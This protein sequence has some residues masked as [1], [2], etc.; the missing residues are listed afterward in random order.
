LARREHV[1][2]VS[3]PRVARAAL[4]RYDVRIMTLAQILRRVQHLPTQQRRRLARQIL[5]MNGKLHRSSSRRS[6]R[7]EW[8]DIEVRARQ[9]AGDRVLPNLVFLDRSEDAR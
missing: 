8:P 6:S 1:D 4:R 9:I 3:P 5:A 2:I 7:T